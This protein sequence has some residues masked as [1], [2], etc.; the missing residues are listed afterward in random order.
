MNEWT[1]LRG[2]RDLAGDLDMLRAGD[3]LPLRAGLTYLETDLEADLQAKQESWLGKPGSWS[4]AR[5]CVQPIAQDTECLK[6]TECRPP[7]HRS[8]KLLM[9]HERQ[10]VLGL[11]IAIIRKAGKPFEP[12]L[13]ACWMLQI[14]W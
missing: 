7:L 10:A 13:I 9:C 11:S 2:E 8:K 1:H 12:E 14:I 3:L 4:T 6:T 5:A